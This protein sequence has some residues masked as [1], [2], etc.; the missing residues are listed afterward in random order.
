[1]ASMVKVPE[2]TLERMERHVN[3]APVDGRPMAV[4]TMGCRVNQFES[5]LMEQ[6]GAARGYRLAGSGERAALVV[7]NTC[8]VTGE[9]DRQARQLIRRAVRENPGARIVVTGCYA[10]NAPQQ[11]AELAGVS[12]VLGNGEKERFWEILDRSEADEPDERI[13]VGDVAEL[14]RVPERVTVDR[15]GD[16]ARAFLQVQD[17]CD[18]AC[19][20]CV[21]P[22]LRGPSRSI[23]ARQVLAQARRFLDSGYRELV[24]T[25][26][27]LGAYGRDLEGCPTLAEL[28]GLLLDTGGGWRLRISSIDPLDVDPGLCALLAGEPRLCGHL[29]L[30]V[31]SGDDAVRRRMGRGRG[32]DEVL[33]RVAMLRAARPEMVL[34]A[35][36]IVG[37]PGEDE[38]AFAKSLELVEEADLS[39]LH[40]FPYSARPDTPAAR[41]PPSML[42]PGD[43]IQS[44]ARR[45]RQAGEARY[46]QRLNSSIGAS[47]ALLIE[48]LEDGQAVGKTGGFLPMCVI[49]A[50]ESWRGA[51]LPVVVEGVDEKKETLLGRVI[52][53]AC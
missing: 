12:L 34:G 20:Y 21:I 26:V 35:D 44:R 37:F 32:R 47:E 4:L 53:Q 45:L 10:Q 28:A 40:V 42:I 23:G 49:P 27:N 6:G 39:L 52:E 33:A 50:Q 16:R 17:G 43:E 25:G 51:L 36:L 13:L 15:F 11:V 8:S 31:Q 38:A 9:S 46:R 24:L 41:L 2:H 48:N 14:T 5:A 1:M 3:G 22:R 19:A 29:H 18:R 7:I 30:S